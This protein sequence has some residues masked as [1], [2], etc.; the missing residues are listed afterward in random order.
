MLS[1]KKIHVGNLVI[2]HCD[3]IPEQ[4]SVKERFVLAHGYRFPV[5]SLALADFGACGEAENQYES[6]W[7]T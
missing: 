6:V 7:R 5:G 2:Q 3:K 1:Y 4:D